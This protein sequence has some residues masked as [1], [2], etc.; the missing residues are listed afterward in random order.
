MTEGTQRRRY[1]KGRQTGPADAFRGSPGRAFWRRA[2]PDDRDDPAI[3]SPIH[4]VFFQSVND[5][6]HRR[7]F[8]R[9]CVHSPSVRADGAP[10]AWKEAGRQITAADS[11]FFCCGFMQGVVRILRG[12]GGGHLA[13]ALA[14]LLH[15]VTSCKFHFAGP[16]VET[17]CPPTGFLFPL[18]IEERRT[19]GEKI[20]SAFFF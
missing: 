19:R 1:W 11:G 2:S 6:S 4:P 14:A 10:A 5:T 20:S 8:I 16:R 13:C 9:L 15:R 7:S 12:G 18:F 17:S 3:H